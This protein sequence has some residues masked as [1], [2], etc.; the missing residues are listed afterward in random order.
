M[1]T[2]LQSIYGGGAAPE[3]TL[4]EMTKMA[5]EAVQESLAQNGIDI[6]SLSEEDLA[7]IANEITGADATQGAQAPQGGGATEDDIVNAVMS[8]PQLLE[9]VLQSDPELAAAIAQ[10][11]GGEDPGAAA[12]FA[13]AGAQPPAAQAPAQALAQAPA[14]AP[15]GEAGGA[16]GEAEGQQKAASVYQERVKEAARQVAAA[17]FTG[18]IIAW[19]MHDELNKIAAAYQAGQ[20]P[21]PPAGFGQ[22][23]AAP[24]PM[25]YQEKVAAIMHGTYGAPQAPAQA[26]VVD[27]AESLR[28]KIGQ[29]VVN[30]IQVEQAQLAAWNQQQAMLQK[31]AQVNPRQI[32]IQQAVRQAF[33]LQ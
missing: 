22:A 11:V 32:A 29:A 4:D 18:R 3:P 30:Q 1:N 9:Q 14:H 10:A 33:G 7:Q 24:A 31:Q 19:S 16:G 12:A 5:A 6:N 15:G 28:I 27:P 21:T 26:P 8:D 20:V 2:L 17:D 25:T 13:G 23:P